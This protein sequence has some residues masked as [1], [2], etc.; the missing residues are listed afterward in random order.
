MA[1]S[2]TTPE[3]DMTQLDKVTGDITLT[4]ILTATNQIAQ[5]L[6][7]QHCDI[8]ESK[9]YG[10]AWIILENKVWLAK[11]GVEALV[12]KQTKPVDFVGT[13]DAAKFAHKTKQK[14]SDA[15]KANEY[16]AIR[17]LQYIFSDSSFLDLEDDQGQMIGTSPNEILVHLLDTN[18]GTEDMDKEI[19]TIEETLRSKYDPSEMPQVYFK[20]LQTCKILLVQL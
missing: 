17:M 19:T 8:E 9:G 7:Q 2:T 15:F 16:G 11:K 4:S 13:T 6:T 20:K 14:Q 5:Q 18:V 1:P 10:H 12:P 3:Y